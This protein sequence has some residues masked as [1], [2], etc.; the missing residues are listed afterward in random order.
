[1]ETSSLQT[2]LCLYLFYVVTNRPI[3]SQ[4]ELANF[5]LGEVR[6]LSCLSL[7]FCLSFPE[8]LE[9][10]TTGKALQEVLKAE[11]IDQIQTTDLI[12]KLRLFVKA[13]P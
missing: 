3:V 5:D 4:V 11:K 2:Y 12:L 6:F 8:Q 13:P 10:K 9:V 7:S 1:M